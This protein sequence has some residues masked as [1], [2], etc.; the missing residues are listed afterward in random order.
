M[1]NLSGSDDLSA[2]INDQIFYFKNLKNILT[3]TD[4]TKIKNPDYVNHSQIN[5][6]RRAEILFVLLILSFSVHFL[7]PLSI[8]VIIADIAFWVLLIFF[9]HEL[10]FT[11]NIPKNVITPNHYENLNKQAEQQSVNGFALA[12][13]IFGL[14]NMFLSVI[15]IFIIIFGAMGGSPFPMGFAVFVLCFA[16]LGIIFSI[17][18]INQISSSPEQYWGLAFGI[19]GLIFN[20]LPFILALLLIISAH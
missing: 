19:L 6:T 15:L 11:N 13:F 17:I 18:G 12:G 14:I 16:V 1:K 5:H 4:T 7:I 3:E 8:L 20:A 2:S 9:I 10:F